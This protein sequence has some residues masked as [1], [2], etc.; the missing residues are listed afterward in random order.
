[1]IVVGLNRN[2]YLINNPIWVEIIEIPSESIYVT[3]TIVRLAPDGS[4]I[5]ES[6]PTTLRL[7]HSNNTLY[8][9][10]SEGIKSFFP[11]PNFELETASGSDIG[12]NYQDARVTLKAV[13]ASGAILEEMMFTR[14]FIRGGRDGDIN[15]TVLGAGATLKESTLIPR[16]QA[17]PVR[18][19]YLTA[20]NRI[21]STVSIPAN[22]TEQRRVVGCNPIYF[23]FLNTQGGYSYW[24]FETWDSE[25]STKKAQRIESRDRNYSLGT[26]ID[27]ELEVEGRVERRYFATMRALIQSPEIYVYN[28]RALLFS[29]A[30]GTSLVQRIAWDKVYAGA[31]KMSVSSSE[32]LKEV[33]FKFDVLTKQ[34]PTVLW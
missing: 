17:F 18:K 25:K 9:D 22:E 6:A 11:I 10:L 15:N 2:R 13:S 30:V 27:Y 1:M 34:R 7:S 32:I 29:D 5:P 28:L 31:N 16:W 4:D 21:A 8:F 20:Q 23:K 12:T 33:K 19:Y 3:A 14:T 26:D 24:L